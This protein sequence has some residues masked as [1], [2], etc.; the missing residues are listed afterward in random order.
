MLMQSH[1]EAIHLLPALPSDWNEGE[2]EGLKARGGFEVD[3]KWENNS[4]SNATIYSSLGGN[5]RIRSYVPLK[6]KGLTIAKGD[7]TNSFYSVATTKESVINFDGTI[8]TET[9]EKVY[10]YDI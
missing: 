9:I 3:I 7:D 1:D 10:E 8:E 6:G 5:C 2:I 4:L